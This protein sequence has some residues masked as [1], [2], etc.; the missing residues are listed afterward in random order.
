MTPRT[1]SVPPLLNERGA[2]MALHES[3]A[4]WLR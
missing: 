4:T 3:A 2:C 1:R